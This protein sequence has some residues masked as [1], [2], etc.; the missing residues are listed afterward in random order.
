[1]RPLLKPGVAV[2][3]LVALALLPFFSSNEV[4]V[5]SDFVL[6][7]IVGGL[8]LHLLTGLTGLVSLGPAAFFG[9]GA[10][11]AAALMPGRFRLVDQALGN[12]PPPLDLVAGNSHGWP[13]GLGL[14]AAGTVSA[15]VALA[16]VPVALR[17][18]DIYLA[19]VTLGLIF[20]AQFVFV[21]WQGLTGGSQG[22]TVG[23]PS[24]GGFAFQ[25]PTAEWG[26]V[27]P[28]PVK[29]YYLWGIIALTVALSLWQLG[30]GR[31]G[32]ALLAI[33]EREGVIG[34]LAMSGIYYK[35]WAFVASGFLAGVAGAMLAVTI[36]FAVPENWDL[37]LSIQYVTIIIIGGI[38]TIRG[39]VLGALFVVGLPVLLRD[40]LGAGANLAGIPLTLVQQFMYGAA[41][42]LFLLLAPGGLAEL[43]DRVGGWLK[44][45]WRSSGTPLTHSGE[46]MTST[47]E[48]V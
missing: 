24:I 33:R 13:L 12:L 28:Q 1:M 36:G 48:A 18:R 45:P 40:L 22:I 46:S 2:L 42:L 38:G 21:N 44:A 43:V 20:L 17:F 16:I 4:V 41:I 31:S 5:V 10:Y 15:L 26:V 47:E 29:L 9:I 14:L 7:A 6:A 30:R 11:T 3:A 37:G 35:A 34:S 23:A 39:T 32:L 8:S 19:I 27:F 25:G